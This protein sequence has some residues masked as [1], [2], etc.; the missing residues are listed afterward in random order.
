MAELKTTRPYRERFLDGFDRSQLRREVQKVKPRRFNK[1][2][3]WALGAS[4]AAGG[5]GAPLKIMHDSQQHSGQREPETASA[6][7]STASGINQAITGDLKAAQNI[8]N[9]VAGG[10]AAAAKGVEQGVQQAA[11]VPLEV[12]AAVPAAI[13]EAPMQ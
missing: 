7:V 8:A 13:A 2:V 4:L 5:I 6:P 1:Y 3:A 10:V 9:Q 11:Q 12:A